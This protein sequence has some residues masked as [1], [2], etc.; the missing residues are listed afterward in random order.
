MSRPRRVL[1]RGGA[2][3][4]ILGTSMLVTVIG[5]SAL[6]VVRV[7][8]RT[9]D[10]AAHAT[11]AHIHV[12]SGVELALHL[13]QA[14]PNWRS[15]YTHDVW[16]APQA[17]GGG[18]VSFKLVDEIDGALG[19]NPADPVRIY[20]RSEVGPTVR[21]ASVLFD[22]ATVSRPN[23]LVNGDAESGVS[24]WQGENC[25]LVARND[26]P[27]GGALYLAVRSRGDAD[28][29]PQQ[30]LIGEIENGETYEFTAWVRMDGD[31][32]DD[33]FADVTVGIMT[34]G[35]TSGERWFEGGTTHVGTSWTRL[36]ATLTPTWSGSLDEAFAYVITE[37]GQRD[38]D[39]DDALLAP[40]AVDVIRPVLGT[41]RQEVLP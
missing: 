15:T 19:N 14:D 36:S 17:L 35:G 23:L 16:A 34:K 31:D 18:S 37:S 13:M 41:W 9:S 21:F 22:P 12:Q 5:L 27:H 33:V 11:E 7:E 4:A 29:G 8:R 6:L 20:A 28:A 3:V 1:R 40:P 2:Y 10:L 32:E 26:G 24:D 30:D 25:S 38:F 39:L